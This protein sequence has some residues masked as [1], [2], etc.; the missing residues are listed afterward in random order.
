MIAEFLLG[1]MAGV[2]GMALLF[3]AT[4]LLIMNIGDDDE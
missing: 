4:F 3:W 1:L 2:V